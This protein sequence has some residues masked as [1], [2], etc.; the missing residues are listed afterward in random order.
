MNN[1]RYIHVG[2]DVTCLLTQDGQFIGAVK[3]STAGTEVRAFAVDP[4]DVII[5]NLK[6]A[7]EEGSDV[8]DLYQRCEQSLLEN[9]PTRPPKHEAGSLG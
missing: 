8:K 2:N 3:N 5:L 4:N 6:G 9:L 7:V 1:I